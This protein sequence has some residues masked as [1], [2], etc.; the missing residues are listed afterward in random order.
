VRVHGALCL[1]NNDLIN[2][3]LCLCYAE[4]SFDVQQLLEDWWMET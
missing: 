4:T 3:L 2:S 1:C